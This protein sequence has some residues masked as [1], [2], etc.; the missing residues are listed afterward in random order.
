[1]TG[2]IRLIVPERGSYVT[3]MYSPPS[4]SRARYCCSSVYFQHSYLS[5]SGRVTGN[6]SLSVFNIALWA[7]R[8]VGPQ[9]FRQYLALSNRYDSAPPPCPEINHSP[10]MLTE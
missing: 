3:A 7:T 9:R 1:M 5:S 2:Q 6:V 4:P 8:S 10:R